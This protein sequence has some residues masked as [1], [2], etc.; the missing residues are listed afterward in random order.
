MSVHSLRTRSRSMPVCAFPCAGSGLWAP[1]KEAFPTLARETSGVP[2]SDRGCE[3]PGVSVAM[4]SLS[5]SFELHSSV[6]FSLD[7]LAPRRYS[8]HHPRERIAIECAERLAQFYPAMLS[9]V[10]F[11]KA[12][13]GGEVHDHPSSLLTRASFRLAAWLNFRFQRRAS[14]QPATAASVAISVSI[15]LSFV[16]SWVTGLASGARP[17]PSRPSV[18]PARL[19]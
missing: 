12:F 19:R 8:K 10:V 15:V 2:Q 13:V 18:Q 16:V 14:Y 9:C 11:R 7:H 17:M 5:V 4:C 1:R 3:L 6:E